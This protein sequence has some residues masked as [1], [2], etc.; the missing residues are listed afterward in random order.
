M[1]TKNSPAVCLPGTAFQPLTLWL[2][3]LWSLHLLRTLMFL[4]RV[5]W[6]SPPGG[7]ASLVFIRETAHTSTGGEKG[8]LWGL[9]YSF[10]SGKLEV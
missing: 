8:C 1:C 2:L 7:P 3:V 9:L 6:I 4:A 10:S 5:C